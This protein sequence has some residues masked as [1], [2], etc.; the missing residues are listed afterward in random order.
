MARGLRLDAMYKS[1]L[2]PTSTYIFFLFRLFMNYS[3]GR[4]KVWHVY[5]I[6]S[7]SMLKKKDWLICNV[8]V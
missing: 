3:Y 8:S 4:Y 1:E 7:N 5:Y 2:S 6:F